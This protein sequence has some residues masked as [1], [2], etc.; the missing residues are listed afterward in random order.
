MQ[1]ISTKQ[2]FVNIFFVKHFK[3]KICYTINQSEKTALFTEN[4]NFYKKHLKHAKY[5]FAPN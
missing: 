3:I 2:N 4:T 1:T 5:S